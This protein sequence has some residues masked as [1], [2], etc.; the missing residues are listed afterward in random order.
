VPDLTPPAVITG[1][2]VDQDNTT[3][4]VI[5]FSWDQ[6]P[7]SDSD[8]DELVFVLDD[9]GTATPADV[10]PGQQLP[11]VLPVEAADATAP[12]PTAQF[13][14]SFLPTILYIRG[15]AQDV[16][17]NVTPYTL[18][19]SVVIPTPTPAAPTAIALNSAT[20]FAVGNN[21]LNYTVAAADH[22]SINIFRS[23]TTPVPTVTPYAIIAPG[24]AI[25]SY[26]F[27]DLNPVE[28]QLYYYILQAVN[29][30]GTALSVERNCTSQSSGGAAAPYYQDTF[31][32][33]RQDGAQGSNDFR[34]GFN[35]TGAYPVGGVEFSTEMKRS[36]SHSLNFRTFRFPPCNGHVGGNGPVNDYGNQGGN[37]WFRLSTTPLTRLWMEFYLYVPDGSE[38][39]RTLSNCSVSLGSNVLTVPGGGLISGNGQN[40]DDG[41]KAI[42]PGAGPGGSDLTV[43][44]LVTSSTTA[45]MFESAPESGS[46]ILN[47][48]T[49]VAANSLINASGLSVPL[50]LWRYY[51]RVRK[52]YVD[53]VSCGAYSIVTNCKFLALY[54]EVYSQPSVIMERRA[55]YTPP[56]FADHV[57]DSVMYTDWIQPAGTGPNKP[58]VISTGNTPVITD[59]ER[60]QWNLFQYEVK[61]PTDD[62]SADGINRLLINGIEVMG[63]YN[64]SQFYNIARGAYL[65]KGYM[66]GV[67]NP[68]NNE[69][70]D[71]Y[72]D[73]IKWWL[74]APGW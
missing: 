15:Y 42:I 26:N 51:H 12:S 27:D 39:I 54:Q 2:A 43:R 44:I 28:G 48:D 24:K 29:A 61:L 55:S 33:T 52:N 7:D 11:A 71:M 25:G 37:Q 36:G 8:L 73:D 72:V 17:L 57:G 19:V 65:R 49:P 9:A 41:R 21:R 6:H 32:A 35:G 60:G 14:G 66:H 74:Q 10:V 47:S 30:G 63:K 40:T 34:W 68:G 69:R 46:L 53:G 16:H 22:D 5:P 23:T 18:P 56:D 13:E 50:K 70:L 45:D 58:K 62:T 4:S 31:G 1:L 64:I 59:T 38:T 20:A 3:N 67:T